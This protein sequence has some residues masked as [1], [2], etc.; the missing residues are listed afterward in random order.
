MQY[1]FIMQ[2]CEVHLTVKCN[3]DGKMK[4]FAQDITGRKSIFGDFSDF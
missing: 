3:K 1:G 4:V 2:S